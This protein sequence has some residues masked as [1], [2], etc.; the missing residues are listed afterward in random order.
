[1]G[2][3]ISRKDPTGPYLAS[4]NSIEYSYQ[5]GQVSQVKTPTRT[6][7]YTYDSEGRLKTVSTPDLGTVTYDYDAEGNLWKTSYPNNLV[8]IRTY[9]SLGRLDVLKTVKVD[10]V[11]QAEIEVVSSFD[12]AVDKVGNRTEVLEQSGRKVE[13]KYDALNRLLEEKITNDPQGNNRVV[14][15]TYDAVGNRLTKTDSVAGL[16]TYTYNNLNQLDFLTANNVVTDY[17]YDDNG[18][19]ILEETGNNST[20]YRW[21]WDGENR[22]MG[23]TVTE[24]GVPRNVAYEYN[25]QGIRV[26]K[27]VDGVETRYLIDELQPYAQVVEEYDAAGNALASYVYGLDLMGRVSGTQPEFYHSD[28]LGSARLL[29]NGLGAVTGT[30]SY[31]AFGN[32][33]VSN[34][35]SDNPYL[36]A[37]EQRDSETGLDYLRARYYDPFVGRFIS[38]DA[39]KKITQEIL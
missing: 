13:Y 33:I 2:Q 7:S 29:T 9:D 32:L 28:G 1:M 37:G 10:P 11:T 12:Y 26:G 38:A 14:N 24:G 3:L 35:G 20:V 18:N 19:L 23:V 25:A 36:F 5:D 16:T 30:Y 31:D 6:T 22:L 21:A 15:Y 34:G 4:G 17:T 27:V 8:E 39:N